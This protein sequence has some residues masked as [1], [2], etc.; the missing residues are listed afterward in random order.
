MAHVRDSCVEIAHQGERRAKSNLRLGVAWINLDS[1]WQDFRP[2]LVLSKIAECATGIAQDFGAARIR[3]NRHFGC[4]QRVLSTLHRMF[5]K[6]GVLRKRRQQG[7]LRTR[8]REVA[9]EFQR[10]PQKLLCLANGILVPPTASK[11]ACGLV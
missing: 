6:T 10:A 7:E 8:E 4:R 1:L 2:A 11:R 9:V 5:K 3:R